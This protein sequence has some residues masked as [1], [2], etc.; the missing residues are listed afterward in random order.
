MA[1]ASAATDTD[2]EFRL[3]KGDLEY[4]LNQIDISEAHAEALRTG[5]TGYSLVCEDPTD[6]SWTCVPDPKLPYGLRTVDGS[7]NNLETDERR[8]YG[9]AGQVFPRLAEPTFRDADSYDPDGPNGPAGPVQTSYTQKNGYVVDYDPR[10]ISNLVVDQTVRNPAAVAMMEQ[11][12]GAYAFDHDGDGFSWQEYSSSPDY[13]P[14]RK[15]PGTPDR[16]FIPAQS[17]D[18]GLSAPFTGWFTLFGQFFDHGLDLVSKGGNGQVLLPVQPD[19]E[20]YVEGSRTNFIPLTRATNLPGADGVLGTGD[21]VQEHV[22]RTTPWIDQN[23]TYTSH[24]SHQV[25]LREYV[26]EHGRPVPTGHLLD[27]AKG[28][29]PTWAE[30]KAQ[31]REVLG[32]ELD[33]MDV[34]SVPLLV[35]D[36]Y[37][38]FVA[39]DSGLPQL[40]TADGPVEG[41]LVAP[42]DATAALDA[43]VAFL[44]D[45]AHGAEPKADGT[46]DVT[47]LE[48]HYLNG[49][50]RGNENIGLTAVH[51]I[52]HSEHNRVADHVDE[53]LDSIQ[54]SDPEFVERWHADDRAWDYGE[55]VFQAARYVTEMEYQHLV[56]EEFVRTIQPEIDAGPLNETLYH[57]DIDPA[58]TAEFA[59][60]VYRF[61]HSMLTTDVDRSGFG[62]ESLPLFDAFLN[63]SEFT[64]GGRLT[65]DQGAASVLQGMAGQTGNGIDEFVDSTLRNQLL[66]VG[67]DLAAIN[68]ARARDTGMPTLQEIR[69]TFYEQTADSSLK[70]YASWKEFE[71]GLKNRASVVNF[72]AAYSTHPTVVA[73]TTVD[74]R[75]AAAQALYADPAFMAG[76]DGLAQVDFWVGG[77]AERPMD[78]G[79]MLG[80]TFNAV[81]EGHME[82][83][84][85]GDRFYYLFRVVGT[86][87]IHQL[88]GN[89]FSELAMRNTDASLLHHDIFADP[90]RTFDVAD[91]STWDDG[92]PATPDLAEIDGWVRFDGEDH[93]NMHGTPQDDRLHGGVGDDSIWGHDGDD[94]LEGW[95]G[96]D[97]LVGRHGDDILQD[98]FG[99]DVMHGGDGNDAINAG[100]GLDLLFGGFG[101]DFVLH[102]QDITQSFAGG[103]RDLVKGG[104]AND[105]LTGNEDD[106]WLE[107]GLGFD[108]LQ[109]DNALT[110]QND[111]NGG[112]D[113]LIAGSGLDDHDAEGG[114]DIMDNNGIDRHIG[115]MGFDWVTHKHDSLPANVDLGIT[116]FQP[117]DV[118][119]SRSRF[120]NVEGASGWNGNDVLRGNSAPGD[121]A[122]ASRGGHELTQA[123]LDRVKGLREL[124]GGGDV[125]R[126]ATA[127]M[128]A[129]TQNANNILL[130]GAGSDILEG[131]GGDDVIDGDAALDFYLEWRPESGPVERQET[132]QGFQARVFDGVI[133]PGDIHIVREVVTPRADGVVDTAVYE[134]VRDMHTI[135]DNGDGTWK[136]A[137]TDGD[138]GG[139]ATGVDILRNIERI[140]FADVTID[141]TTGQPTPGAASGTIELSTM[142]PVE[143]QEISVVLDPANPSFTDPDGIDYGTVT[144]TW[145]WSDDEGEW[146]DSVSGTGAMAFTPG[147]AEL[148]T[149]RVVATFT[150]GAGNLE[151]ITSLE[152][153]PVQ[154]V[155]DAPTYPELT[156]A[157]PTVG[158]A[159]VFGVD[160]LVDPDGTHNDDGD[161]VVDLR[162]Q[163]FQSNGS[164]WSLLPGATG[165]TFT[166]TADQQDRRLRMVLTYTDVRGT[167]ERIVLETGPVSSLATA[168]GAPALGE[169][170]PGHTSAT[171]TWTAPA[172]TGG[173][174]LLGYSVEV[175]DL[176]G[177][178]VGPL[179][180]VAA[181]TTSL[182]VNGL[183]NGT[184]YRFRVQA[185]NL[186]GGGE[187][188]QLSE[189]VTP[190][191]LTPGAPSVGEPVAGDRS[192]RVRWTAP[193]EVGGS[194]LTG[195]E[196]QVISNGGVRRVGGIPASARHADVTDLVNGTQYTFAVRAVNA[197]VT[198]PPAPHPT[199]TCSSGSPRR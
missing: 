34:L 142:N 76:N 95:E 99:A 115:M 18:V 166:P 68:I 13:D 51:H 143:D 120:S 172:E 96:N 90:T 73:E 168:P 75:R 198:A 82:A 199:G 108:L 4:I 192:A 53:L 191:S 109:G 158:E 180:P 44:D 88:E 20:L 5:D 15:L 94:R 171:V 30:V 22:N 162:F 43:G 165:S 151:S 183:A 144:Y 131:R 49:D 182:V 62:T 107:G 119:L 110:F 181:G 102:G 160:S 38:R 29:A 97:I 121:P 106:D 177:N 125:P 154:N 24:P 35:T 50:G 91:R 186:V 70:P 137:Y 170:T 122:L 81:F 27:G 100:S 7:F 39:G 156:P 92:D 77:L 147:D 64:D 54:A 149:L 57:S 155:N 37:G 48:S 89:S 185:T 10:M 179:R 78:F 189:P 3:T 85:N 65:P 164:S 80:S 26:L 163:W 12:E 21:D 118:I 52:F 58:V 66:G 194:E 83:L 87:L 105:V 103:G 113:V 114:D 6:R 184:E 1:P 145:Q 133:N 128:T 56:F 98:R 46:H 188:S 74:G 190:V 72:I 104:N 19:D 135:T 123:H 33:D 146:T 101:D 25:F 127:F 63:P 126:Y 86:N 187:F 197:Q 16:V 124:L 14:T 61:G 159:V 174:D 55:R 130:G 195:Y 59:H 153:L 2:P 112:A 40:V 141:L 8:T 196:V 139:L 161:L 69:A 148:G 60:V 42:A 79:G 28:G 111:P 169:V 157:S 93:V 193:T 23:Q 167:A 129:D 41:D 31:A 71:L 116:A 136:V 173:L 150:D 152:T 32:I 140:R 67:L 45:I 11:V 138:A 176:D 9:A 178:R 47:L 36:P 175:Q 84:Q 117:P 134:D 17:P 132:M